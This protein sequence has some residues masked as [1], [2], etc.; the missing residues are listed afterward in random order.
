MSFTPEQAREA[1]IKS[2]K[3]RVENKARRVKLTEAAYEIL[4]TGTSAQDY[5]DKVFDGI[6]LS[7]QDKLELYK[8]VAP[9]LY[10]KAFDAKCKIVELSQLHEDKLELA[11]HTK[12][13]KAKLEVTHSSKM[14]LSEAIAQGLIDPARITPEE[15]NLARA[16]GGS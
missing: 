1:Q 9:E 6:K 10:V 4:M 2:A 16:L 12:D 15:I 8:A 11:D 7:T 14:S 13:H 3:A 5:L